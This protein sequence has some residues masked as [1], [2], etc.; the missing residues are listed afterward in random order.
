MKEAQK[1][2]G[3]GRSNTKARGH[4][5]TGLI[6]RTPSTLEEEVGGREHQGIR[7]KDK[8]RSR[9]QTV[10]FAWQ[11]RVHPKGT[12]KPWKDIKW[13]ESARV[14]FVFLE[15][16]SSGN[17]ACD[18]EYKE[19]EGGKAEEKIALKIWGRWPGEFS[20]SLAMEVEDLP[21]LCFLP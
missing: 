9:G 6:L 19:M 8:Q 1:I 7:L 13:E 12:G 18:L 3:G 15:D 10:R 21:R 16:E 4:E 14:R 5:K 11:K 20:G 2:P 17:V